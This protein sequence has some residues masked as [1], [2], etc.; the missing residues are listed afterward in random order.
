MAGKQN[1]IY[2]IGHS[3]RELT[4][5]MKILSKYDVKVILDVRRF[6]TS[7]KYPWFNKENLEKRLGEMGIKYIWL[8]DS[9]GGYR[10]GGY[11][12][13]MKTEE[14]GIGIKKLINIASSKTSAI[15]CSEKLW[16]RCHRRFIS[17]TLVEKG[18]EVIHIIDEN[19]TYRH[20]NRTGTNNN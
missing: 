13:Y 8:G 7:R 5:L 15:M 18:F 6:P 17:D 16:F 20:R 14:Y 11:N 4:T 2:T 19:K 3:N 12:E 9:L 10:K 1:V